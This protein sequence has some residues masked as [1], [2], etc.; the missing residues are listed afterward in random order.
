[1]CSVRRNRKREGSKGGGE[2]QRERIGGG[3][4][5]MKQR[6][7]EGK[8]REEWGG[9]GHTIDGYRNSWL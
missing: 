1:M 8:E 2:G 6:R 7:E 9:R 4:E 5:G 3:R